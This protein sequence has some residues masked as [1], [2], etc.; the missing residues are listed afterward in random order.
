MPVTLIS[1]SV[2]KSIMTIHLSS[3]ARHTFYFPLTHPSPFCYSSTQW[4]RT[5]HLDMCK[6]R[7]KVHL[8]S[9]TFYFADYVIILEYSYLWDFIQMGIKR[10]YNAWL[11][12]LELAGWMPLPSSLFPCPTKCPYSPS[13]S[14]SHLIGDSWLLIVTADP[15]RSIAA[16]V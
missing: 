16:A 14:L 5:R 1:F 9:Y 11:L 10:N 13:L 15:P 4:W 8:E 7:T 12:E 6:G 2:F 3:T